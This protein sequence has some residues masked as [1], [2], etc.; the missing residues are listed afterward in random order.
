MFSAAQHQCHC[1]NQEPA[2]KCCVTHHNR[3]IEIIIE[4]TGQ[5][6]IEALTFKGPNCE[7][8]TAFLEEALGVVERKVKKTE[9]H[10]RA[11]TTNQQKLGA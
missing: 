6:Q 4:T 2:T 11:R 8:A 5:I 3:T 7:K 9:F 10:Q 1:T